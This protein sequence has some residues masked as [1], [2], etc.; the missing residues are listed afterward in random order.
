MSKEEFT[1]KPQPVRE[2]PV[3]KGN[4]GHTNGG[5]NYYTFGSYPQGANGEVEP[6]LWRQLGNTAK[7]GTALLM[8]EYIL[9]CKPYY[10]ECEDI[11]WKD[12]DLRKWLN[13]EFYNTAFNA[14]EKK[15]V[16]KKRNEG[17]GANSANDRACPP[18]HDRVFLLNTAEVAA[19]V[20]EFENS[21]YEDSKRRA[22]IT[23]WLLSEKKSGKS[24]I[25]VYG[26]K[27]K[28]KIDKS[29]TDGDGYLS[30]DGTGFLTLNGE[31]TNGCSPWWLRNRG[32]IIGF[33]F[34]ALVER[35]GYVENYGYNVGDNG[36][37]VR[38]CVC[39]RL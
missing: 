31:K 4:D 2:P 37:G 11:T 22:V 17:N 3:I 1:L 38:P 25:Y 7:D 8:S 26:L 12:C 32:D 34:A 15:Q 13:G 39:V 16:I 5:L 35:D 27:D 6:I 19:Y 10:N 36:C 9:D 33:S 23:P 29:D 24:K 20:A 30:I 28:G 21:E 18:T 14:A